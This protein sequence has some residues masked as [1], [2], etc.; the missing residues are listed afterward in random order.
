M[1]LQDHIP[2]IDDRRYDDIVAELRTRIA[3]YTPEWQPVWTDVNDS[4]PG[5]T[6]V[7]LFAWLSEMLIYRLGKVP[8]LNY[9]KFLELLGVELEP[10]RPA[11]VEITFPVRDSHTESHVTIPART[12]LAAEAVGS[13][14]VFETERPLIALA[15][16]LDAIQAYDGYAYRDMSQENALATEGFEP[17]GPL[18]TP[19]S[20]LLLGFNYPDNSMPQ[21]PLD[22]TF[23]V[24]EE[25]GGVSAY[26]CATAETAHQAPATIVWEY[27]AGTEWQ[28]MNLLQDETRAFTRSGLVQLKTPTEGAMVPENIGKLAD[29]T[30]RYWVRARVVKSAFEL[31]PQLLAVRTNTVCAIQA[32]TIKGE[33]L[34]GSNGRPNQSFQLDGAPVLADSL[35]LEVDEGDGYQRWQ[36]VGDFYGSTADQPHFLLNRTTGEVRFGD[37]SHG[38]IPVANP[39]NPAANVIAREYRVG[40]GKLGNV[41]AGKVSA[42]LSSISG[43][44]ANGVSNLK[45]AHS[46]RDEE[47]LEEAKLRAPQSLK[48]KDRAVTAEDFE[49]LARQAGNVR[50]AKALPLHHPDFPDVQVP[51]VITVIVVPDSEQ[52]NPLPSEGTLRTVCAY[53]N[54]RRLLTTELYVIRPHYRHV[55]VRAEI[56]ALATAD[57]AEVKDNIQSALTEYFHPLKGGEDGQ[58]WPFGGD[59][60]FSLVY[61]R[62]LEIS[63]VQRIQTLEM[64][65]DGEPVPECTDVSLAVDT[66]LYS[67]DHEILVM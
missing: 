27:W 47:T 66:L 43:V 25:S 2:R 50:R 15:A 61:R 16:R 34:G 19:D 40:G 32:E 5:I 11:L 9:I 64:T 53:L 44:D 10:A 45:A 28:S 55:T 3:R 22:I 17:F 33:V 42:M 54:E 29:D 35:Q 8:Q 13:S 41:A 6:L 56:L 24:Q 59:I 30:P 65:L 63:G 57:V 62:I 1:P 38:R 48:N 12:Q 23:W 46:G 21:A 36:Q 51:G 4:D 20:A 60:Y 52:P 14:V 49:A 58:G 67:T 18:A 7:Q 39:A 31:S 37:G 26:D